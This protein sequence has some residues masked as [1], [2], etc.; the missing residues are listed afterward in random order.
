MCTDNNNDFIDREDSLFVNSLYIPSTSRWINSQSIQET[1]V[2]SFHDIPDIVEINVNE[3]CNLSNTD[4]SNNNS[5]PSSYTKESTNSISS[6]SIKDDLCKWIIE[7]NV[8]QSTANKLLY[9]M[10]QREIINTNELPWDTRTL[11]AT[12]RAISSIRIV[13]PGQYYHFG[14]TSGIIRHASSNMT[15]IK[16]IIGIHGLPIAKSSNSQL[17]PI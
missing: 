1:S 6:S 10:K 11:L 16:I 15:E 7:C 3:N 14:L 12:P 13:E 4:Q 9:L 2:S 17:W 8:P 5:I